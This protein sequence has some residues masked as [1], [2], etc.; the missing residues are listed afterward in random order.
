ML[1]QILSETEIHVFPP[2][3]TTFI[4]QKA[5]FHC[6]APNNGISW[7][8]NDTIAGAIQSIGTRTRFMAR[9]DGNPGEESVLVIT[10]TTLANNSVIKCSVQDRNG[11][12]I[13]SFGAQLIIQG[14]PRKNRACKLAFWKCYYDSNLSVSE[15]I[16]LI[17]P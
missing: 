1:C 6:T 5:E 17:K 15:S 12:N 4:G 8:I 2:S 14:I 7:F 10:A 11:T 13:Y 16:I 3:I 9:Q